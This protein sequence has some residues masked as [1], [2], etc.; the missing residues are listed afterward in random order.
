MGE[1]K[2][3]DY[4]L[5]AKSGT[6]ASGVPSALQLAFAE[7][8]QKSIASGVQ[9]LESSSIALDIHEGGTDA[10]G[11]HFIAVPATIPT[12]PG[13]TADATMSTWPGGP[14]AIGKAMETAL[15]AVDGIA[16]AASGGAPGVSKIQVY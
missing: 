9:G 3:L 16:V 6:A 15:Q 2:G 12:P 4:A 14:D 5:L 10:A 7:A 1:I 8:I 11:V 13:L